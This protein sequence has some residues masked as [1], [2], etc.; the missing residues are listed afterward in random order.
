M[1]KLSLTIASA[2]L[3]FMTL[4][5]G[6]S[7]ASADSK[8]CCYNNGEYFQSTPST[9]NRYGG[10]T[11]PY[12]YCERQYY[13]YQYNNNNWADKPCCRN[14]GQF[15]NATPTTCRRYGGNVV[16]QWRCDRYYGNQYKFNYNDNNS[17]NAEKPCCYNNGQYFNSTPSTCRKHGGQT[18]PMRFC[19]RN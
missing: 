11:V 2:L 5:A 12:E 7:V 4:I 8:P 17:F 6:S 9:C 1:R 3:A 13:Q 15:F 16:A 14:N 18:V 19:F 10:R